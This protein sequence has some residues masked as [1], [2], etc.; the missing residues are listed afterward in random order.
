MPAFV[1]GVSARR[2]SRARSINAWKSWVGELRD[3]DLDLWVHDTV[4]RGRT[5]TGV[6]YVQAVATMHLIGR[7]IAAFMADYDVLLAPDDGDHSAEARGARPQR[8]VPRRLNTLTANE[9][10]HVDRQPHR[11]AGDVGAHAPDR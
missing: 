7:T 4:E 10:L 1:L 2:T 11:A 5:I 3:D 6:Q 8:A 9:R